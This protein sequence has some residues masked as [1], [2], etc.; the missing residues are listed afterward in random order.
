[1]QKR[2]TS[3][4]STLSK[5]Q[6]QAWWKAEIRGAALDHEWNVST[7]R[8]CNS[9]SIVEQQKKTIKKCIWD[10]CCCWLTFLVRC[11]AS[12]CRLLFSYAFIGYGW[13]E[14]EL[15]TVANSIGKDIQSE[16]ASSA[17]QWIVRESF[18]SQSKSKKSWTAANE[19]EIEREK[20]R[21]YYIKKRVFVELNQPQLTT[22][23]NF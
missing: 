20:S 3:R 15:Q 19:Q 23:N 16:R 17:A 12:Y 10:F 1:M 11:S 13:V 21:N 18:W 8:Q 2:K 22:S 7:T 9:I 14:L 4:R 5:W 6:A